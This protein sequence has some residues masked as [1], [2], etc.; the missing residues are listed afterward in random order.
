MKKSLVIL[1][2]L[3]LGI[4]AM[5][6]TAFAAETSLES[7][8]SVEEINEEENMQQ[9]E[10]DVSV[11]IDKVVPEEVENNIS[12]KEEVSDENKEEN[13]NIENENDLAGDE[14]ESS[15][16][17]KQTLEKVQA[18]EEQEDNEQEDNEQEDNE[19]EDDEQEN[20]EQELAADDIPEKNGF[21]YDGEG[22]KYYGEDGKPVTG[23]SKINGYLYSF[24][25]NGYLKLGFQENENGNPEFTA[26]PGCV[27]LVQG[28]WENGTVDYGFRVPA[29]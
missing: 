24:D 17:L 20:D 28:Q 26:Q 25:L 14:I 21:Y 8:T 4:T 9:D 19:Q 7:V 16:N 27:Y 15:D 1:L 3:M 18:N 29:E 11:E 6:V 23:E 5:P 2:T 10:A 12:E 13:V 22:I